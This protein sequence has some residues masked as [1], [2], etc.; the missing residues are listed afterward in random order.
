MLLILATCG[1]TAG[2]IYRN[3][4][5]STGQFNP[6]KQYRFIQQRDEKLR[7]LQERTDCL[8]DYIFGQDGLA[9]TNGDGR[10]SASEK[11]RA[12]EIMVLE[13]NVHIN[14]AP[15]ASLDDLERAR[16]FYW[17]ERRQTK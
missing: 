3:H 8:H 13:D 10:V 16:E 12:Y 2:L 6:T 7:E 4:A 5:I 17:N 9:D 15:L 1:L 14:I 11:A